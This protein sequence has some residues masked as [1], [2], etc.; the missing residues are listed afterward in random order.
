MESS[1][2]SSDDSSICGFV[3]I[4][5]WRSNNIERIGNFGSELEFFEE[6]TPSK[7]LQGYADDGN[8]MIYD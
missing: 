7:E 3:G 4:K 8:N 2:G 5:I 6:N 1:A